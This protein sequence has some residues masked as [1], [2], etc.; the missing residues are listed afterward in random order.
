MVLRLLRFN[1]VPV[2][3]MQQLT[4][5]EAALSTRCNF[6]QHIPSQCAIN[7]T[8]HATILL[9]HVFA[10]CTNAGKIIPK[11][12]EVF[13]LPASGALLP[14]GLSDLLLTCSQLF[15]LQRVG[16]IA[17]RR[18]CAR[19]LIQQVSLQRRTLVTHYHAGTQEA[20]LEI[21]LGHALQ[22]AILYPSAAP[23]SR[24]GYES[25]VHLQPTADHAALLQSLQLPIDLRPH[26]LDALYCLL[27][28]PPPTPLLR[29]ARVPP[30]RR[31]LHV[32]FLEHTV[33]ALLALLV[34]LVLLALL[35]LLALLTVAGEHL[36]G[37]E[38]HDGGV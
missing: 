17:H 31:Y 19:S 37:Q 33:L 35:A 1:S 5:N 28:R 25:D 9:Q 16:C 22:H 12:H 34:L 38:G 30:L 3:R 15:Y 13:V 6:V 2:E 4:K 32:P 36:L 8:T 21:L 14:A 29:H 26:R 27:P 24:T 11:R 10:A 20:V 18:E 7:R 23:A